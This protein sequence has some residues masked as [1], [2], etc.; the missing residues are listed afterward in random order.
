MS[1]GFVSLQNSRVS[2]QDTTFILRK[3]VE[4]LCDMNYQKILENCRF[5]GSLFTLRNPAL[6]TWGENVSTG[7]VMLSKLIS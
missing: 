1:V 6:L 5:E 4:N 3:V 7:R 2:L